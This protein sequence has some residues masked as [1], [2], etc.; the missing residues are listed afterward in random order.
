MDSRRDVLAD[1]NRIAVA[2]A[3]GSRAAVPAE[4]APAGKALVTAHW[5]DIVPAA[6]RVADIAPGAAEQ[7]AARVRAVPERLIADTA[8][9]TANREGRRTAETVLAGTTQDR[10]VVGWA[11]A[12]TNPATEQAVLPDPRQ[13]ATGRAPTEPTP[14]PG[15]QD[16]IR[17]PGF[18][19]RQQ[20]IPTDRV[21][22]LQVAVHHS[23]HEPTKHRD[24]PH[25][26]TG[27]WPGWVPELIMLHIAAEGSVPGQ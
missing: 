21:A 4:A 2:S 7:A 6:A 11:T 15:I 14:S 20:G 13:V 22:Q 23:W 18:R 5:A 26:R 3:A 24:P 16:R 25:P 8:P 27:I 17:R 1:T 10:V 9:K 19:C 12:D